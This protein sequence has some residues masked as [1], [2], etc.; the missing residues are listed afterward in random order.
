ML[1]MIVI[2]IYILFANLKLFYYIIMCKIIGNKYPKKMTLESYTFSNITIDGQYII[3][4]F[5]YLV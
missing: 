5:D 2:K 3:G 4:L 1:L